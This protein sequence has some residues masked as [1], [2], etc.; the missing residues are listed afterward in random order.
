M[1]NVV[2][3][4]TLFLHDTLG[5]VPMFPTSFLFFCW[6]VVAFLAV[7]AAL[8]HGW[9]HARDNHLSARLARASYRDGRSTVVVVD[10]DLEMIELD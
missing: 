6:A 8:N 7:A 4:A 3:A 2:G 10:A 1:R 5:G 9:H